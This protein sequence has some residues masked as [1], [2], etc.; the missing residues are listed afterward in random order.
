M[1]RQSS[2]AINYVLTAYAQGLMQDIMQAQAIV[3]AICPTVT[4]AGAAGGFKK[5]DDRNTFTVY[6][7]QRGLGGSARRIEFNATDGTFNCHPQALEVT[8]DDA[9]REL[10]DAGGTDLA[11]QLLDQ[12]KIRALLNG[13]ALS[14]VSKVLIYVAANTTAVAQRGNWSNA[15]IDPVD[16]LDE[17]LDA[18]S[19]D[20]GQTTGISVLLGVSSW[21]ALRNHPKVKAR[22]N[23][24]QVGGISR[25]QLAG[26]LLFPAN[27]VIGALSKATNKPGQSTVT[28]ANVI[29]DNVYLS[30][31]V[32]NP[33]QYD[34]S[35]FKCFTTGRGNIASVRTYR[36]D[37]ARSDV[38]AVDWSEDLESTS[39]LS[40]RRLAIT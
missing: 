21:R 7:T 2:A 30:Y 19:V 3:N 18:L 13:T 34:P 16:Q 32:P 6:N 9:E 36:D 10:A 4:V 33:T 1:S 5:F 23:G 11:Q 15:D 39:S 17:Q 14:H 22:C 8:V 25:E 40:V 26:M 38:H 20:V 24:V 35:P 31:S 28:K 29:G 37:S 27:I 12:G